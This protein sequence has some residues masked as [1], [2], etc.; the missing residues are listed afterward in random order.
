MAPAV[1][2]TAARVWQDRNI[3]GMLPVY[4]GAETE[5]VPTVRQTLGGWT[6][7]RRTVCEPPGSGMTGTGYHRGSYWVVELTPD[8]RWRPLWAQYAMRAGGTVDFS[9]GLYVAPS[10]ARGPGETVKYFLPAYEEYEVESPE[11]C[12]FQGIA[13]PPEHASDFLGL[14]RVR[15]TGAFPWFLNLTLPPDLSDFRGRQTLGGLEKTLDRPEEARAWFPQFNPRFRLPNPQRH[16]PD[17]DAAYFRSVLAEVPDDPVLL[18]GLGD[19]LA[20]AG[21]REE[22]L[23][24]HHEALRANPRDYLAYRRL[25][26]LLDGDSGVAQRL[27]LW[28]TTAAEHPD[29]FL[30]H[31]HLA[32]ALEDA[33]EVQGAVAEYEKALEIYPDDFETLKRAGLLAE[34]IGMRPEAEGFFGRAYALAPNDPAV[35][36]FFFEKKRQSRPA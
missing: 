1:P 35:T 8:A 2:M 13:L 33:G 12:V 4:L 32:L 36:R 5:E 30:P 7:F 10:P 20:V 27:A 31:F 23:A 21:N 26:A 6:L 22:A 9:H 14:H 16:F 19:A 11:W 28:Q 34:R 24:A 17:T 25:D 29:L 18:A 15:N 3:G